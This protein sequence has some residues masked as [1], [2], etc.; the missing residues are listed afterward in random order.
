MDITQFQINVL[1]DSTCSI[2]KYSG[3][4][5][6]LEVP[7]QIENAGKVLQVTEIG[8]AAFKQNHKIK[9]LTLPDGITTLRD[10]AFNGCD[11]LEVVTL[12][13]TLQEMKENAFKGCFKLDGVVLP[14][15]L[16]YWQA[17]FRI[18]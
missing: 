12:P 16:Y 14:A 9:R 7:A 5:E 4:D 18:L 3:S 13:A 6:C 8:N 1:S 17:L 11:Q 15:S 10:D 2:K